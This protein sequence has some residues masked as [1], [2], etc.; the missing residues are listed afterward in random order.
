MAITTTPISTKGGL[1]LNK[2]QDASTGKVITGQGYIPGLKS[3]ADN[4][5]LYN[6]AAA[7]ADC[8]Q[9]PV[10]RIFKTETVE[11]ENE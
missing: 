11:L 8:T 2:G 4:S 9:Y 6:V 10:I 3:G 5:K 1:V 7:Y